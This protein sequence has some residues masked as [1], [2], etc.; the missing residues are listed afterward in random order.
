LLLQ[1]LT[2]YLSSFEFFI[3]LIIHLNLALIA[4]SAYA[5][6]GVC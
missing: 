2:R 4:V 3:V 1:N 6:H 5:S